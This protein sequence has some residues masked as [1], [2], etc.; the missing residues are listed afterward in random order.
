MF[1]AEAHTS[2]NM[3]ILGI[4][5]IFETHCFDTHCPSQYWNLNTMSLAARVDKKLILSFQPAGIHLPFEEVP[6]CCRTSSWG[7]SIAYLESYTHLPHVDKGT[8]EPRRVFPVLFPGGVISALII[9][10]AHWDPQREA[11]SDEKNSVKLWF[12]C[13]NVCFLDNFEF[14]FL[15]EMESAPR[16]NNLAWRDR[17]CLLEVRSLA[18]QSLWGISSLGPWQTG[19]GY[20][21]TLR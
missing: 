1:I 18:S 21:L 9:C 7:T 20:C 19:L 13:L 17:V 5:R 15:H 16:D 10:K 14:S 8:F 12:F 11:T 6:D 4:S 2:E 3:L